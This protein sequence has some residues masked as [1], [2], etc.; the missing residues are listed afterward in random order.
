MQIAYICRLVSTGTYLVLNVRDFRESCRAGDN[1]TMSSAW[2]ELSGP[3]TSTRYGRSIVSA[4]VKSVVFHFHTGTRSC[5]SFTDLPSKPS[6]Q[7][8]YEYSRLTL[9]TGTV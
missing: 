6:F 9:A 3:V 5:T 2:I 8:S 1:A 4:V 7:H